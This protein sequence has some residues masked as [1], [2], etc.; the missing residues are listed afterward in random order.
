MRAWKKVS[1]AALKAA[2]RV[3]LDL[4]GYMTRGRTERSG[5]PVRAAA[6]HAPEAGRATVRH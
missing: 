5:A 3:V 1:W 6:R 4:P 2:Q